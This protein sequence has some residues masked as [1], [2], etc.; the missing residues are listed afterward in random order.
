MNASKISLHHL[1]ER[2]KSKEILTKKRKMLAILEDMPYNVICKF[3]VI[4][5]TI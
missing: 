2:W 5:C 4:K 1:H 3:D